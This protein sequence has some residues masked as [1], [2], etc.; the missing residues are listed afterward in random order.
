MTD[1]KKYGEF[2]V[3]TIVGCKFVGYSSDQELFIEYEHDYDDLKLSTA[4]L[5]QAEFPEIKQVTIVERVNIAK[6]KQMIDDL[7]KALK[8][9]Q[10]EKPKQLLD[11]GDF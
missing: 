8:E 2:I 6:A 10:P 4:Q 11:I 1:I 7:N 3:N 9:E 5:L